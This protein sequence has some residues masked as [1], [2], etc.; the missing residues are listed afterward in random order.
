MALP[1]I[2]CGTATWPQPAACL[3]YIREPDLASTG[4]HTADGHSSRLG[5]MSMS[6]FCAEKS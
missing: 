3:T 6:L 1:Q 2:H 4:T 5:K